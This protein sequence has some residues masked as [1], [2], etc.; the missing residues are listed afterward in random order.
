MTWIKSFKVI[1][2]L[3]PILESDIFAGWLGAKAFA[4]NAG[5]WNNPSNQWIDWDKL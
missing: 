3:I 5:T 2:I 4:S 1:M